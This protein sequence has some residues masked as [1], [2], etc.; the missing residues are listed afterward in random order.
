MTEIRLEHPGESGV[1]REKERRESRLQ[2][3]E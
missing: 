1:D 2:A 3:L